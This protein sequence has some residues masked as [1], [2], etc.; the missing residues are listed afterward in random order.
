MPL[1][2]M[3]GIAAAALLLPAAWY[4]SKSCRRRTPSRVHDNVRVYTM[5]NNKGGVG[6]STLTHFFAR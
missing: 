1:T 3:W 5:C 4:A 6:K 2:T